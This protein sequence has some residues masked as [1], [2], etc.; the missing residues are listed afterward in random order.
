VQDRVEAEVRK[1]LEP[2][3]LAVVDRFTALTVRP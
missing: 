3:L 2:E 1:L